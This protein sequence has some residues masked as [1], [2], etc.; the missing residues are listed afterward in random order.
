MVGLRIQS[1]MILL[2]GKGCRPAN[3]DWFR[4]LRDVTK[5]AGK[6]FFIKQLGTS[7]KPPQR[8]LDCRIWEE[9]PEGCIKKV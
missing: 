5:A 1:S 4:K 2:S 8:E 7:H 9:F 3:L 6:P